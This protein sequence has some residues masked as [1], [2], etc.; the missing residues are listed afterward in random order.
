MK[1]LTREQRKIIWFSFIAV[2]LLLCFWIFVYGSQRKR[3]SSIKME[4]ASIEAQIAEINR[5][6]EGRDLSEAVKDFNEELVE[7]ARLLPSRQEEI[8][9]NLSQEARNL[10]IEV[11]SIMPSSKELVESKSSA[12]DIEELSISIKLSCEFRELGM[13]LDTLRNNFPVLV[14]IKQLDIRGTGEGKRILD[15]DLKISTYLSKGR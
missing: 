10:G 14:R 8:I 6:S 11:K 1:R 13:Y 2:V 4:L 9:F 5:I 15:V 12:F 3:L 7:A